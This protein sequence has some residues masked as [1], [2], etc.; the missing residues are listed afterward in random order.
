MKSLFLLLLLAGSA[1]AVSLSLADIAPRV[2]DHHPALQAAR[3]AV[4][5]AQGRQLGAGR[6]SN[7]TLGFDW[8][9]ESRLSPV[10]GEFSFEQAFPLTRRLSLEK[11]LTAQGVAAAEKWVF[12]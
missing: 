11:Q 9:S 10:T 7:P 5:E 12:R 6:L 4:A 2:R 3:L 8:R 1:Q